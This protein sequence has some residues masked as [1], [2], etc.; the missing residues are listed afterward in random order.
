MND[1]LPEQAD[2]YLHR[3]DRVL[4]GAPAAVREA[5]LD[6]VRAHI[7]DARDEGRQIDEILRALGPA[8]AVAQ[9][10]RDELA[11]SADAAVGEERA[12][13]TL[14]WASVFIGMLTGVFIAFL[15][16][17]YRMDDEGLASDEGGGLLP[18]TQTL[19]E[20]YGP[21]AAVLALIP[22]VLAA[23]PFVLPRSARRPVVF[24]AAIAV[25]GLCVVAIL[26]VGG[27]Y[28]PLA[29]ALW[30][31]AIVPWRVGRGLNLTAARG[32]R[33]LLGVVLV[34]P[35]LL[36]IAGLASGAILFAWG[37]VAVIGLVIGLAI[38]CTLGLRWGYL[39]TA[40]V[41]AAVM[42]LTLFGES[43]LMLLFWWIGGAYAVLGLACFVASA[44]R[45]PVGADGRRR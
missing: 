15:L 20:Q 22:A 30:A 8:D 18:T 33:I 12:A 35:A 39:L 36:A 34:I 16:P 45:A 29:A 42:V 10:Y 25:T 14:G 19:V 6:D 41:G 7:V 40:A 38:L 43:L 24:A 21:G 9:Q 13:K 1:H 23:L 27:F 11:L 2:H 4:A 5:A 26:S 37:T 31:A 28:A 3:L 32:W 44:P 17:S